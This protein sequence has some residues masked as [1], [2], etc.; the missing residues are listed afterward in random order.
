[1]KRLDAYWN[2]LNAISLLLLPLSWLFGAIAALRRWA[3]QQGLLKIHTLPVPVIVVGNITVGGTGKTP[4]V[5]WLAEFLQER[6]LYPGIIARGYGSSAGNEPRQVLAQSTA[7]E[8]GDEPLLIARRTGCPM[9]VCSDRVAAARALLEKAECDIIISDDGMQHYALGRD[10][11][12][13]VIDGSRRF[14]N[15]FS[16]PAGPLRERPSR[17]KTVDLVVANGE[18]VPA[19]QQMMI[20]P[21][22]VVNLHDSNMVRCLDDFRGQPVYAV[23]GIGN[24]ARYFSMLRQH[25]LEIR[26]LPF[27]DH[28]GFRVV[29]INPADELPV[30]MTEKDAVKCSDF[31]QPRHWYVQAE[32]EF[33]ESFKQG[34]DSLLR[35][36]RRG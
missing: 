10:I 2:S 19:E 16:L 6:G 24:P 13:A 17:L 14:G 18:A 28:H 30:L 7:A 4:L 23:A 31:A 27:P 34:L 11:E 35:G 36:I 9:V 3:Y 33:D 32:V 8:V 20:R 22:V 29:D 5:V 21:G 12:I 1:V 26:E 25:G 15:G